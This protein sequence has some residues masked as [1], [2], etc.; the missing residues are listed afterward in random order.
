L[1]SSSRRGPNLERS[2]GGGKERG[3]R[4]GG[5]GEGEKERGK[6][7][8]GKGEGEK[9]RGKRRGEM[10]DD[11]HRAHERGKRFSPGAR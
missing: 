1:V 8:G 6:R 9:E 2:V 10:A 5:K 4:R 11:G 3:K 7:R